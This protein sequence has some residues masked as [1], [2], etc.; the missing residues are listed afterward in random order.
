MDLI[1]NKQQ[2][3]CYDYF[4]QLFQFFPAPD[5]T[6]WIVRAAENQHSGSPVDFSSQIGQIHLPA[7]VLI[8]K[9][10]LNNPAA[11]IFDGRKKWIINRTLNN[12]FISRT[13]VSL[14]TDIE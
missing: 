9:R 8:D 14:D 10:I 5:P 2:I 11:I 4:G 7:I 6:H 1:R 13:G 12:N 3:I